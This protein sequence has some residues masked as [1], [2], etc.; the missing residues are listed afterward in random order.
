MLDDHTWQTSPLERHVDCLCVFCVLNL[1]HVSC[2][3][4]YSC[5]IQWDQLNRFHVSA[6]SGFDRWKRVPRLSEIDQSRRGEA[7]GGAF[8]AATTAASG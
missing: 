3:L 5:G 4:E 2:D 7:L 1:F 8:L 6:L